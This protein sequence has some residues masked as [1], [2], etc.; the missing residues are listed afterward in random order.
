[1]AFEIVLMFRLCLPERARG[2]NGGNDLALKNT[3]G[4]EFR[5]GDFGTTLLRVT[6]VKDGGTTLTV[7]AEPGRLRAVGS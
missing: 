6:P 3:R 4:I 5:N 7:D 2:F 1:M